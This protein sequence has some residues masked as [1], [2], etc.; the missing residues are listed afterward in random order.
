MAH[1]TL[2][3]SFSGIALRS[4]A[5]R[6]LD[7]RGLCPIPTRGGFVGLFEGAIEP[8]NAAKNRAIAGGEDD[9]FGEGG[10]TPPQIGEG[11]GERPQKFYDF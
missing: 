3:R 10:A 2:P 9:G 7:S 6:A 8:P 11:S 5:L 4:R 1:Q